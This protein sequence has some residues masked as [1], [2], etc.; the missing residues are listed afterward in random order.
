MTLIVKHAS[1]EGEDHILEAVEVRRYD[2]KGEATVNILPYDEDADEITI[3]SGAVYV[4]NEQGHT[5]QIYRL[6]GGEKRDRA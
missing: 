5:I 2:N 3:T 6:R 1:P 4:M